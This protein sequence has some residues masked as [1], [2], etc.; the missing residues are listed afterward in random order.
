M[1]SHRQ[2][3]LINRLKEHGDAIPKKGDVMVVHFERKHVSFW[4]LTSMDFMNSNNDS[5]E[6]V[7]ADKIENKYLEQLKSMGWDAVTLMTYR[8]Q[9]PDA[10]FKAAWIPEYNSMTNVGGSGVTFYYMA[11]TYYNANIS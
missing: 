6:P 2:A 9:S 8:R 7:W 1:I 4:E 10:F 5:I 3:D 11:D